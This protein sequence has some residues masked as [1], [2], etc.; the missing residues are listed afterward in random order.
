MLKSSNDYVIIYLSDN[1][2]KFSEQFVYKIA[3]SFSFFFFVEINTKKL[4][5]YCGLKIQIY[6]KYKI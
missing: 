2:S 6:L 1:Q 4:F 5:F 3:V